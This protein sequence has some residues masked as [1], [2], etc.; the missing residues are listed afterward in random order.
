MRD[1]VA[2]QINN[3]STRRSSWWNSNHDILEA[4]LESVLQRYGT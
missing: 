3:G 2:S 1:A 4:N